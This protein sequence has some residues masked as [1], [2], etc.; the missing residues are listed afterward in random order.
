VT[1]HRDDFEDRLAM[2]RHHG[3]TDT[4]VAET[5]S[6]TD[7]RGDGR[8]GADYTFE[9]TGDVVSCVRRSAARE[10]WAR[11]DHRCRGRGET[12]T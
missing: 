5:E 10:A 7:P 12:P 8:Y 1:D 6:S 4:R 2:A 9:A 3:A 11:H